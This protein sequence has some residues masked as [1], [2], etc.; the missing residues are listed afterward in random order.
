MAN[1]NQQLGRQFL[2]EIEEI[3]F[4][5]EP[6]S[7]RIDLIDTG[8]LLNSSFD[9]RWFV[10]R[11]LV[12]GQPAIMG[13][14]KKVL[15]TS[16]LVDLA[17]SVASGRNFLNHFPIPQR[18]RVAMLSGESGAA[19]IQETIR[20][21]CA[22]KMIEDPDDLPAF[23]GFVLPRLSW[24]DD[25]NALAKAISDNGIELML[26]DP[27]YLA[28]LAGNTS[29]QASN[30]FDMGPILADATA[31]CLEAGATPIFAHHNTKSAGRSFEPPELEDMAF[32]GVQEFARQWILLGRREKYEPGTGEHRLWINVGGS[33]GHS[34]CWAV[35][36]DEGR[37]EDDFSGRTWN[38]AVRSATEERETTRAERDRGRRQRETEQEAENYE[39]MLQALRRYPA[40][41]TYSVLRD[42]A[43]LGTCA[44]AILDALVDRGAV[45]RTTVVKGGGAAGSRPYD[46]YR[47]VVPSAD[48]ELDGAEIGGEDEDAD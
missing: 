37:L 38:V 29:G 41:E 18:A 27:L 34:G 32:A 12:H 22:S 7:H 8:T 48:P 1:S 15:K 11:L 3:T 30:L 16:L 24:A 31:A 46:G 19:T 26:L 35:D 44:R 6:S 10:Q 36:V 45:E 23:W 13:G 5:V 28:L 17:V 43:G 14:A 42:S 21:V 9:S 47:L 4:T 33:A 25:L 2:R 20:R 40:G 39:Q